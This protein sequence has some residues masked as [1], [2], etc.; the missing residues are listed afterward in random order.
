MTF[1]TDE[2]QETFDSLTLKAARAEQAAKTLREKGYRDQ[3]DEAEIVATRLY[4]KAGE[5]L[6]DEAEDAAAAGY[7]RYDFGD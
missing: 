2:P 4:M 1:N 5:L 3:A 7:D 6:D